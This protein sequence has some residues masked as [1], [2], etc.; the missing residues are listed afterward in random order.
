MNHKYSWHHWVDYFDGTLPVE[1]RAEMEQHLQLCPECSRLRLSVM[2]IEDRLQLAG[3]RLRD[4]FPASEERARHAVETCLESARDSRAISLSA[5]V[6]ERLTSL[7]AFMAP[8][9]GS[10]TAARALHA[11]ARQTSVPSP[12]GLTDVLWPDFVENL[13]SIAGVLCGDPAAT[14]VSEV[15][16]LVT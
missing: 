2:A 8:L 9:C 1:L 14:L 11:A 13:S 10:V 4:S 5:S 12:E 15:G 3:K 16:R 7:Q 6:Q